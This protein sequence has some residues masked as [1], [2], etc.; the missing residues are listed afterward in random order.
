MADPTSSQCQAATSYVPERPVYVRL[1]WYRLRFAV[2]FVSLVIAAVLAAVSIGVYAES[3][4]R[5]LRR[6]TAAAGT[7]SFCCP[8]DAREAA[9]YL[10]TSLDP[11][12]DFYARVCDGVIKFKLWKQIVRQSELERIMVTGVV[13]RA[14]R[15]VDATQ[16]IIRYYKSCI[17]TISQ[18]D[19]FI[20]NM[21]RALAR[22]TR[23]FLGNPDSR[24]A[25]AYVAAASLWYKLP[26]AI[27]VGYD[28]EIPVV[29]LSVVADTVC[30]AGDL[31]PRVVSSS[32]HAVEEVANVSVTPDEVLQL[33]ARVCSRYR[34][35]SVKYHWNGNGHD[36]NRS[37]WNLDDLR[38]ALVVVGYVVDE[39]TR[40]RVNDVAGLR[41]VL[42]F[43]GDVDHQANGAKAGYLLLHSLAS[44]TR[45]FYPAH[46]VGSWQHV[47]QVCNDSVGQIEMVWG[48][49]AAEVLTTPEKD[50][51]LRR[52]FDAVRDAVY[53]D[54][55][56]N[57]VS[58]TEDVERL[59]DLIGRLSLYL[60][61]DARWANVSV[62]KAT[63]DF[64]ENLLRGRVY[65][66]HAKR[67]RQ[68]QSGRH[69]NASAIRYLWVPL[70]MYDIIR[71]GSEIPDMATLGWWMAQIIWDEVLDSRF[72]TPKAEAVI[73]RLRSCFE[74]DGHGEAASVS[75]N[76]GL[77]SVLKA[78]SRPDWHTVRQ[79]WSLLRMSH[80]EIFYT[81]AVYYRCPTRVS[82]RRAR[83]INEALAYAGDIASAFRCPSDSPMA[84]KSRCSL[85]QY[86]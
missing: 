5:R 39:K 60:T 38:S 85:S 84:K 54:C 83:L 69:Q 74:S 9:R 40:I 15:S 23:G 63:R 18:E 55:R 68:L 28:A 77:S 17:E 32:A 67:E 1:S 66:F 50:D 75:F 49:F 56:A 24:N 43:Y 6:S 41:A 64:A 57:L 72:W 7:H 53:K 73:Q 22:E 36:F 80:A 29:T 25:L 42:G 27:E 8:E 30:D 4:W 78:F 62:P 16:F 70:V 47:F 79:A 31:P 34:S 71:T 20:S 46:D 76:L 44:L 59:R 11:C 45:Q 86:A 82:P 26:S 58:D 2:V 65:D 12:Q 21:A 14:L 81:L 19:E 3:R 61:M 48:L 35:V 37:V 52:I 33:S 10:N 51:R 13:P